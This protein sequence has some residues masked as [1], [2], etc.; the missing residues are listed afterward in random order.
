MEHK[1]RNVSSRRPPSFAKKRR[2]EPYRY[3]RC[4]GVQSEV[5]SALARKPNIEY[6]GSSLKRSSLRLLWRM[7]CVYTAKVLS[8]L[9]ISRS[10][11]EAQ[12]TQPP[13]Q[14]PRAERPPIPREQ[15]WRVSTP[16]HTLSVCT[17]LHQIIHRILQLCCSI[18]SHRIHEITLT[19]SRTQRLCSTT[20]T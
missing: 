6:S 18:I 11:R 8:S 9:R 20:C 4:A 17:Q 3:S 14:P 10:Q 19:A 13:L 2:S 1:A 5:K 15:I 7:T 12:L 16:P